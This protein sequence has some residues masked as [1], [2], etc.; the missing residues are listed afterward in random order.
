MP[1]PL[2]FADAVCAAFESQLHLARRG[3]WKVQLVT[4]SLTADSES[5]RSEMILITT[6]IGTASNA[7]GTPHRHVQD[8]K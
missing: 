1:A 8:T 7:P 6:R 5:A 4:S 2:A 3:V